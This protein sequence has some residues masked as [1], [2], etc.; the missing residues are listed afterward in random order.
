M[1]WREALTVK[2]VILTERLFVSC[3]FHSS[4]VVAKVPFCLV[5][6]ISD[7]IEFVMMSCSTELNVFVS[8]QTVAHGCV[9]QAVL[10]QIRSL[11]ISALSH[12]TLS[13]TLDTEQCAQFGVRAQSSHEHQRGIFTHRIVK[14]YNFFVEW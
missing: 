1:V 5:S 2:F 7:Q 9:A 13:V 14:F 6:W 8:S 11:V 10:V 4:D 12:G 3:L